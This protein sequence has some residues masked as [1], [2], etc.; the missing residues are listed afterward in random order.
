LAACKGQF[1]SKSLFGFFISTKKQQHFKDFCPAR[2]K[3]WWNK[4]KRH[5]IPLIRG[6]FIGKNAFCLF[7]LL[8]EA[9]VEILK[10]HSVV[11]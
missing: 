8:L 2:S 7:D 6:R 10:K 4:K 1:I 11:F 9:R 5:I 3:K